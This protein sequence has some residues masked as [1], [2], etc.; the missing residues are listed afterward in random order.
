MECDEGKTFLTKNPATSILSV[1]AKNQLVSIIASKLLEKNHKL[2]QKEVSCLSEQIVE[3]YPLE[4]STSFYDSNTKRGILM[5]KVNN[6]IALNRNSSGIQ[7]RKK[8]A[9]NDESTSTAQEDHLFTIDEINADIYCT[10]NYSG[11]LSEFYPATWKIS[12]NIRFQNVSCLTDLPSILDLYKGYLRPDGAL[13]VRNYFKSNISPLII[14]YVFRLQLILT[15]S[16]QMQI[17][18][19]ISCLQ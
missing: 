6:L 14:Y 15:Q 13:L 10:S 4:N 5:S 19:K 18:S 3:M 17:L 11:N 12:E 7:P 16:I 9:R 8:R 1:K 2:G